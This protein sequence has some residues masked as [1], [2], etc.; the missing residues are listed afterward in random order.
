MTCVAAVHARVLGRDAAAGVYV[1]LGV[2]LKF[3]PLVML[4]GL[5]VERRRLRPRLL[6]SAVV[7]IGLGMTTSVLVWGIATFRPLARATGRP[8]ELLSIFQFLRGPWSPLRWVWDEP[9]VDALAM[10][11][12]LAALL[13]VFV[14]C[15]Q[16]SVAAP[17]GTV[18]AVVTMLLFYQVGFEQYQIVLLLLAS[19][20]WWTIPDR[21]GRARDPVLLAALAGYFGWLAVFDVFSGSIGGIVRPGEPWQWWRTSRDCRRFCSGV[22]CSARYC[23]RR[24]GRPPRPDADGRRGD[25]EGARSSSNHL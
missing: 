7:A 1:A 9:N 24:C 2:L 17:A 3:L 19:Y 14:W 15:W 12:L 11:C 4:P 8:S 16:R 5:I 21:P 10:P 6:V 22:R 23:D 18:L 25:V 20:L 13:G